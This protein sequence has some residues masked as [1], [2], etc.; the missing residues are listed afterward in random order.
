MTTY[1]KLI[2]IKLALIQIAQLPVRF[3][4]HMRL[5]TKSLEIIPYH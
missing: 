4:A 2:N 3:G 5:I 1:E